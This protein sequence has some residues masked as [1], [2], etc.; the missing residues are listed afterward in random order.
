MALNLFISIYCPLVCWG[1][2]LFVCFLGCF[3]FGILHILKTS[4]IF[5]LGRVLHPSS[6][7]AHS[8]LTY[9]TCIS[10]KSLVQFSS[11]SGFILSVVAR[12][13]PLL[14]ST[15]SPYLT[16][17]CSFFFYTQS[18]AGCRIWLI[19]IYQSQNSHGYY[20]VLRYSQLAEERFKVGQDCCP[21]KW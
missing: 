18:T 13:F 5:S 6:C 17:T 7:T 4:W 8:L 16:P 21:L 9:N 19:W 3:F 1:F 14:P 20:Q 11:S 2:F 10:S 12:T 15:V